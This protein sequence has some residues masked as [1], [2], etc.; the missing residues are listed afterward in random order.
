MLFPI[1]TFC[2][3]LV[4]GAVWVGFALLYWHQRAPRTGGI[5]MA[6]TLAV[7]GCSLNT[8]DCSVWSCQNPPETMTA[9]RHEL[10]RRQRR[11]QKCDDRDDNH[12]SQAQLDFSVAKMKAELR[13][14]QRANTTVR[15]S[16]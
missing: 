5:L 13:R 7:L 8:P 16:E 11:R 3:L 12:K 14:L 4:F 2:S 6:V 1:M 9:P 15:S 10:D